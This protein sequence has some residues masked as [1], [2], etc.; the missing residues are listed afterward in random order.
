MRGW[1]HISKHFAMARHSECEMP[2]TRMTNAPYTQKPAPL[3]HVFCLLM[4]LI[5]RDASPAHLN[6]AVSCPSAFSQHN[7]EKKIRELLYGKGTWFHMNWILKI[8]CS[9]F[10]NLQYLR[11]SVKNPKGINISK[12]HRTVWRSFFPLFQPI[13]H[14]D[15]HRDM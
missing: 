10:L 6:I 15:R 2:F 8:A 5:L 1:E 3:Q 13:L 4:L 12:E 14:T 7:C 11:Y 9:V